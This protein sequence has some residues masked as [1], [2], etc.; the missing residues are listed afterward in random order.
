SS[1]PEAEQE[2]RSVLR[3]LLI[4]AVLFVALWQVFFALN[5]LLRNMALLIFG[6]SDQ[7]LGDVISNTVPQLLVYGI[8]WLYYWRVRTEDNATSPERGRE[9]TVRRWY[10]YLACF[11]TLSV[12]MA[13]V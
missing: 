1:D 13:S 11:V 2:R 4:Y 5:D 3:K 6:H 10:F 12:L 9:S 7:V 8:A